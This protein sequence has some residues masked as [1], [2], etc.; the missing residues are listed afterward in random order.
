MFKGSRQSNVVP[1]GS[2]INHD[3]RK[4]VKLVSYGWV[5]EFKVFE[6]YQGNAPLGKPGFV[7]YFQRLHLHKDDSYVP[8]ASKVE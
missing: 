4:S 3:A 5:G 1:E 2:N 7:T 6:A 8:Q